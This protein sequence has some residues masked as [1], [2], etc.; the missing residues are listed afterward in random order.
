M[1]KARKTKATLDPNEVLSS[2]REL[3]H[4]LTLGATPVYPAPSAGTTSRRALQ[5]GLPPP[6]QWE[7][8]TP[9]RT[10]E[11][12]ALIQIQMKLLNK[13]L[14]DLK[15]ID[16]TDSTDY[17]SI[18]SQEELAQRV[19]SLMVGGSFG[20]ALGGG[21]SSSSSPLG[22]RHPRHPSHPRDANADTDVL[23]LP[24]LH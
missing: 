9:D 1:P 2:V 6:V 24:S 17:E 18:L 21:D 23:D 14:P 22:A 11:L 7:P 19:R 10:K 16:F 12:Q 4:W 3:I 5:Q 20:D 8:L 15:A 13:V